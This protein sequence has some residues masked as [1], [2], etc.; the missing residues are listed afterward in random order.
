M[1]DQLP[2]GRGAAPT[3]PRR[4]SARATTLFVVLAA[5]LV[6]LTVYAAGRGQ[7]AIPASEVWGSIM[8]RLGLDWGP[9]P[10]HPQGDNTL[11][12]VRFPRIAMA[13]V[14]GAALSSAGALMQGIFGNPLAEPS[15]VGVST[16]AAFAA[17]IVIVFQIQLIGSWTVALFAFAGGLITTLLVYALSRSDGRTEVVTLVLTGIAVNAVCAAGLALMIF[18]GDTQEREQIVFWQLGSLNGSRWEHVVVVTPLVVVG[19]IGSIL[20]ARKLDVLALGDRAARHVGIDVERLRLVA[21]VL[22]AL[23]TAAGVS[24]A[25]IIAFV[26]LVVPH[27]I[28][29]LVGPGHR[30]LVPASAL[31]GAVLL[32]GADLIARTAMTGADLPIGM[33]TSLVGGPFFFWLLRRT[34]KTAGGWA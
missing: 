21:I 7:L 20:M 29:M 12:Q 24:F 1:P 9:M 34:R 32:L 17:A 5:A 25:G 8:H 33:L 28:R 10:A 30:V 19:L 13:I 23:L 18:L 6:V 15:V 31:A 16:G 2:T 11:W 3:L 22:V 26:G 14:V 4:H 27:L